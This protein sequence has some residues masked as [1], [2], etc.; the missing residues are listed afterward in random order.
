MLRIII[1]FCIID[2]VSFYFVLTILSSH[3]IQAK[4]LFANSISLMRKG[5]SRI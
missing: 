3:L 4:K 2:I 1:V 5:C